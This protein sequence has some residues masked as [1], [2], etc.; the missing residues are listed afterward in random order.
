VNDEPG[1]D[2]IPRVGWVAIVVVVV[3][4]MLCVAYGGGRH[5]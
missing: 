5:G 2:P 3:L 1:E 4:V